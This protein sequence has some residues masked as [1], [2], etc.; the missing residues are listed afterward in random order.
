[1]TICH[2]FYDLIIFLKSLLVIFLG[3]VIIKIR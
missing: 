1:M 2:F 3:G